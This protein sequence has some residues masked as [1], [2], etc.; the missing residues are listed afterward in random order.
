M[1]SSPAA[2]APAATPIFGSTAKVPSFGSSG[3]SSSSGSGKSNF[4]SGFG[5]VAN[6]FGSIKAAASFTEEDKNEKDSSP[7]AFGQGLGSVSTGFGAV[8]S[9]A[10]VPGFGS[11]GADSTA[12]NAGSVSTSAFAAGST[13]N[14]SPGKKFI[15]RQSVSMT[16]GEEDEDCVCEVRAKF[17]RMDPVAPEQETE[18]AET[19]ESVVPSVPS[20]SGRMERKKNDDKEIEGTN[21]GASD[22]KEEVKMDWHGAGIGPVL[23]LKRKEN[24]FASSNTTANNWSSQEEDGSKALTQAVPQRETAPGGQGTKF[25]LNVCLISNLCLV[26]R[27]SEL[28]EMVVDEPL[29]VICSESRLL[30]KRICCILV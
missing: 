9:S 11:N 23:F 26:H 8:I 13:G 10:A 29:G 7:K 1:A 25:I 14:I 18:E 15:M 21:D 30:L 4:G 22:G 3:A 12:V 16:N 27:K 6:G 24:S 28:T 20:T 5:T 2:S 19:K 17:F